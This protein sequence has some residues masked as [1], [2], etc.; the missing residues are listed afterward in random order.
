MI[1]KGGGLNNL[2][3]Y[4]SAHVVQAYQRNGR[5]YAFKIATKTRDISMKKITNNKIREVLESHSINKDK[6]ITKLYI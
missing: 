6:T 5:L 3:R 2:A 4:V 1:K